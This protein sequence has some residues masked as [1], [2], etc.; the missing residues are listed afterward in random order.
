[1]LL[2]SLSPTCSLICLLLLL[3]CYTGELPSS[4]QDEHR[5][6]F[7]RRWLRPAILQQGHQTKKSESGLS[8][9]EPAAIS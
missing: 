8:D 1:M 4:L 3:V 9:V 5:R 7:P 2:T 6:A